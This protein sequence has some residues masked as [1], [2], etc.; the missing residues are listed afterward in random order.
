MST[1]DRRTFLTSTAVRAAATVTATMTTAA[2]LNTGRADGAEA[3]ASGD[4]EYYELRRYHLRRG[5]KQ[6]VFDDYLREAWLPAMGRAGVGPIGVFS[7]M[8]GPEAPSVWVLAPY[9]SLEEFASV[10]GK[11]KADAE[12]ARAAAEARSAPASDPVYLAVESWLLRS[13]ASVPKLEVPAQ[14]K[15]GKGR[16]FELR[17]YQSH[18]KGAN[19]KK[20]EM[21]DVGETALF[22]KAGLAPVFFGEALIGSRLPNLTYM[23]VFDD[24]AARDAAWRTFATD[25]EWKKLSSTPGFTDAE[26][27]TDIS[28]VLLRPAAYSQL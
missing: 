19:G 28:N 21:F 6:K 13:I 3:G 7:V 14:A 26:I 17:T 9:R 2:V 20:I 12:Y 8:V 15:A 1:L 22:R 18:N 24:L 5:P 4:R 27:V 11:L 23:L 16:V 25:P 10:P